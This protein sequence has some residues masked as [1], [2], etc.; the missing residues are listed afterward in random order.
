MRGIG[1]KGL[2]LSVVT[3]AAAFGSAQA[4]DASANKRG[5]DCRTRDAP[6]TN[7]DCLDEYLGDGFFE[8]A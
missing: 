7:Y 5:T 6:Y 2:L 1:W 4:E 8:N 3:A